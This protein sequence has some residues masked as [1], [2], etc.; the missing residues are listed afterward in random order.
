MDR[1]SRISNQIW[2]IEDNPD[3]QALVQAAFRKIAPTYPLEILDSGTHAL[4][5]LADGSDPNTRLPG[6]ILVDINLPDISGQEVVQGIKRHPLGFAMPVVMLTTSA[7]HSDIAT[8]Y[9]AGCDGYFVKPYGFEA[10]VDTLHCVTQYWMH[11][12]RRGAL[13][14]RLKSPQST[15]LG[16]APGHS[17]PI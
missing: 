14:G 13:A 8:C 11:P 2:V 4:R 1:L 15:G 16:A 10:L 5:T 3:D 7:A 17:D 9:A 6:L 12:Y